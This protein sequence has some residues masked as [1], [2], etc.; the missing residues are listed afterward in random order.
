[1]NRFKKSFLSHLKSVLCI[2]EVSTFG[3]II[4]R[5]YNKFELKL[6]MCW[7]ATSSLYNHC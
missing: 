6:Y 1:M 7:K 2:S 4:Y 3:K 5:A